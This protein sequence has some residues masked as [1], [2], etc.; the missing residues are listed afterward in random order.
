MHEPHQSANTGS[1]ITIQEQDKATT[2]QYYDLR[3]AVSC[4]FPEDAEIIIPS[5]YYD[6]IINTYNRGHLPWNMNQA[7]TFTLL[8]AYYD[9]VLKKSDLSFAGKIALRWAHHNIDYLRLL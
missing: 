3:L 6:H 8:S 2:D 7:A 9:G 5:Y 4:Y 1:K